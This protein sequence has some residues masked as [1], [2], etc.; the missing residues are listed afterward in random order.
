[1]VN[2]ANCPNIDMG[3]LPL[4]LPTRRPDCEAPVV[5]GSSCGGGN[6]FQVKKCGRVDEGGGKISY[7]RSGSERERGRRRWRGGGRGV[8]VGELGGGS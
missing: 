2:M 6:G 5:A 1:M 7:L 4:E 3:F 8:L